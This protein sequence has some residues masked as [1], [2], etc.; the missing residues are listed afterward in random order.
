ME[1]ALHNPS[2]QNDI[3]MY[4]SQLLS[5]AT[6]VLPQWTHEKAAMVA[7]MEV[8]HGLNNMDFP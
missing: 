2:Q 7:G 3:H 4:I 5:P 1:E 8:T 6:K